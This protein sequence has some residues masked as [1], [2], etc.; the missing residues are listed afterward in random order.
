VRLSQRLNQTALGE[1]AIAAFHT[2]KSNDLCAILRSWSEKRFV[3][4]NFDG[5][6]AKS[7][8]LPEKLRLQPAWV[9]KIAE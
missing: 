3:F 9:L 5:A 4:R 6:K 7:V 8:A 1:A 2:D